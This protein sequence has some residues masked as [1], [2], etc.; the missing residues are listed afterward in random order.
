MIDEGKKVPSFKAG[1]SHNWPKHPDG[2]N[3]TIGEMPEEDRK[4][5]KRAASD[6]SRA[7]LGGY[8]GR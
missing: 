5:I 3:M 8:D 2:T 7:K 6:R 1:S 4:R